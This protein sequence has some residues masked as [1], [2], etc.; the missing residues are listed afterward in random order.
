MYEKFH[1]LVIRII[2][3]FIIYSE[4]RR[5]FRSRH[6]IKKE[7][8][9]LPLV[10]IYNISGENNKVI[11]V[12]NGI[13]RSLRDDE[14]INE[15]NIIISSNNNTVKIHF[16]LRAL[17]SSIDIRNNNCNIE[18]GQTWFFQRVGIICMHGDGQSLVIGKDTNIIGAEITLEEKGRIEIGENC[19]FSSKIMVRSSDGHSVLDQQSGK[20]INGTAELIKIGNHVWIGT[21]VML[22]KNC[23]VSDDSIIAA[24][25]IVTKKFM[26]PNVMLAG[27]PAKVVKS[28]VNWRLEN[29]WMLENSIYY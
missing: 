21:E 14:R 10:K 22:L 29:P 15:L 24:R 23:M 5:S 25:S 8:L 3:S 16:P 28:G 27:I 1:N 2:S 13:E 11:I 20:P 19:L 18:I 7:S 4:K 12:E 9:S 26:E 6:L 17:S